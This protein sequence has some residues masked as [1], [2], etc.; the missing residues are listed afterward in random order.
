MLVLSRKTN[1]AIC[2]G[3]DIRLT[4]LE[5]KGNTVRLGIEAPQGTAVF[6]QELLTVQRDVAEN[7]NRVV[8]A[9]QFES[10]P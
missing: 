3:D 9:G 7:A 5:S 6:R 2:I 1:E 8:A 10:N 4:V